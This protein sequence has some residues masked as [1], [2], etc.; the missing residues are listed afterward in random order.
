M[1]AWALLTVICRGFAWAGSY[2]L[3]GVE[4]FMK[5]KDIIATI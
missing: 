4:Y 2:P 3:T 5:N 1:T